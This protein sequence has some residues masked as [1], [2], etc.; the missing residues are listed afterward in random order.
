MNGNIPNPRAQIVPFTL[1]EKINLVRGM[2]TFPDD[3]YIYSTISKCDQLGFNS[4]IKPRSNI[5]LKDL[6]RSLTRQNVLMFNESTYFFH[7]KGQDIDL[8]KKLD[9]SK[10]TF[11]KASV[12]NIACL[13]TNSSAADT[14]EVFASLNE[15]D[16]AQ[17]IESNNNGQSNEITLD[18]DTEWILD[19]QKYIF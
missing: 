3:P 17:N 13:T 12:T 8:F 11:S 10:L 2:N 18:K 16:F 14:H 1:Q 15:L 5:N 6:F 7:L 19:A 4:G 9:E